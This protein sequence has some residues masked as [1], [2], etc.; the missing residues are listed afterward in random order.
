VLH[1]AVAPGRSAP[2][3][4]AGIQPNAAQAGEE[5]SGRCAEDEPADVSEE[6]HAAAVE[7][8]LTG[9]LT[10]AGVSA[11]DV[12]VAVAAYR[13]V[14][15]WLPIPTGALAYTLFRRRYG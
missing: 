15:F 5:S 12:V 4:P 14:S 9:S 3:K 2:W 7:A 8:G 11:E 10:L 13:I 1:S 6:R